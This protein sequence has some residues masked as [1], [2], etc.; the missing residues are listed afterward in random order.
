MPCVLQLQLQIT[1]LHSSNSPSG[2]TH[3]N[4]ECMSSIFVIL[5]FKCAH[6]KFTVYG[7]K[8]ASKL[9]SIYT[10]VCNAVTLLWGSLRLTPIR[11]SNYKVKC[12]TSLASP[13]FP[14]L[15]VQLSG[16]GPD[17]FY[18][19][20]DVTDRANYGSMGIM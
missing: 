17:T 4:S 13:S 1:M 14:L 5:K 15:A 8:Q 7:H 3:R 10:H 11:K 18:H 16:R 19:V 9:A 20:S 6:L 12:M 2:F